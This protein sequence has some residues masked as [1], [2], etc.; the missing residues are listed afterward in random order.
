MTIGYLAANYIADERIKTVK[1]HTSELIH[2]QEALLATIAETTARNGAD[3]IIDQTIIDCPI[4]ERVR[5]DELLSR[6]NTGL[7]VTELQELDRLFGRCGNFYAVRKSVMVSRLEREVGLYRLFVE[8][9][10]KLSGADAVTAF[11]VSEWERLVVLERKQSQLFSQLVLDQDK[12]IATLLAG[13]SATS[14]EILTILQE[15]QS[16]QQTLIVTN[17][18]A[19]EVRTLLVTK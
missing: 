10:A 17:A 1:E 14:Q 2:E 16:T 12:I 6:L 8:Q 11:P 15:V 5:F 7:S 9:L 3:D 4:D 18:Q 19:A 13:K